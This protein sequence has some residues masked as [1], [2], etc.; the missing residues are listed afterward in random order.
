MIPH[1]HSSLRYCAIAYR[2]AKETIAPGCSELE[3]YNA[4]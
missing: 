1:C 4:M 2:A 3:G